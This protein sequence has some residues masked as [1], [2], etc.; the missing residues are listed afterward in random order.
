M[1]PDLTEIS[2]QDLVFHLLGRIK[3]IQ[4]ELHHLAIELGHDG[5][6]GC[7]SSKRFELQT[8]KRY[9]LNMRLSIWQTDRHNMR[10]AFDGS[11]LLSTHQMLRAMRRLCTGYAALHTSDDAAE[12]EDAVA[13]PSCAAL[14]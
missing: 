2:V 13:E 10:L 11:G 3:A 6:H 7:N 12:D 5:R 4:P 1:R 8:L 9:G 14:A